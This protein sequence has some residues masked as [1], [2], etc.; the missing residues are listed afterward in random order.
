M[1][2]KVF[3]D[4][5]FPSSENSSSTLNRVYYIDMHTSSPFKALISNDE[6]LRC[7]L[8][9]KVYRL[10]QIVFDFSTRVRLPTWRCALFSRWINKEENENQIKCQGLWNET[11]YK[12]VHNDCWTAWRMI[13]IAMEKPENISKKSENVLRG[14]NTSGGQA[15]AKQF[16]FSMAS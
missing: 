6:V 8:T 7:M 14:S 4:W 2:G 11:I 12:R 16:S 5:N 15:F 1:G 3:L 10:R 13:I 9:G